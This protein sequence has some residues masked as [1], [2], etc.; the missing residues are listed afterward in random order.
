MVAEF[1]FQQFF[2][3]NE[4]TVFGDMVHQVKNARDNRVFSGQGIR[5][6]HFI[7]PDKVQ[8]SAE[9]YFLNF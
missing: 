2:Q 8:R 9:F 6:R 4:H 3:D 1:I 5:C 7:T